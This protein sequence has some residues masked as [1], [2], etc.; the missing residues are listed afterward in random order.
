MNPIINKPYDAE[1]DEEDVASIRMESA[2]GMDVS[3]S[4]ANRRLPVYLL[5]DCSK[6]M[7]G[8][9]IE[10][11][12]QGIRTFMDEVQRDTMSAETV[13]VAVITF[14]S[15]A[16]MV[17]DGLLPVDAFTAPELEAKGRTA[18]GDALNLLLKSLDRDV[19][20][21]VVGQRRADYRPLCFILTDGEPTD[22]DVW[23]KARQEV[24]RRIHG[25]QLTVVTV[26]CGPQIDDENLRTIAMGE[27]YR[28]D[29][30][31]KSFRSFFEYMTMSVISYSRTVTESGSQTRTLAPM[32]EAAGFYVQPL[33]GP[34]TE[35]V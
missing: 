34:R 24:L 35:T 28:L 14:G 9:P 18:L 11:V 20:K 23:P 22:N 12:Q 8:A 21:P 32:P 10:A 13:H 16:A 6:S 25:N 1:E 19:R 29:D 17:T 33:D 4:S 3:L 2:A 15:R 31:D 7:T 26:G 27:A 30:T 5:L